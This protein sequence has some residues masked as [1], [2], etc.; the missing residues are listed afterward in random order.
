MDEV[1]VNFDPER[2][3]AVAS[4]IGDVATRRQVLVFTCHPETRG[5]MEEASPGARV[6]ELAL[7]DPCRSVP[8][9]IYLSKRHSSLAS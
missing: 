6:V 5:M 8:V 4:A 1:L 2:A 9:G 3:K 7:I